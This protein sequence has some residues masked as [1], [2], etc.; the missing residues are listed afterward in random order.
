MAEAAGKVAAEMGIAFPIEVGSMQTAL[1]IA[2]KY[3][4]AAVII[5]R[6]G[7]AEVVKKKYRPSGGGGGR[8]D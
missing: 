1:E 7:T 4:Q 2:A 8:I 5:S 3:P 6:G